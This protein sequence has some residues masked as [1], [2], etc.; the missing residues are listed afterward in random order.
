MGSGPACALLPAVNRN[1][2]LITT[3]LTSCSLSLPAC[4]S[5][6]TTGSVNDAAADVAI[7][8]GADGS[9]ASAD[10]AP[11]ASS[12]ATP[13]N[14][15]AGPDA[16]LDASPDASVDAGPDASLDAGPDADSGD[17]ALPSGFPLGAHDNC[18]YSTFL[19]TSGGGGVAGPGGAIV[20]SQ[21]GSTLTVGYGG[22][23]GALDTSL[24]F[25]PTSP[26]SATLAA[27]QELDGVR[28]ACGELAFAPAVTQLSAGALT[29]NAD[30][31]FLSVVGT[32]EPLDAGAGCTNP[33]G[34]VGF[35]VTCIDEAAPADAGIV[36]S[37]TE[38]QASRF[39][40]SYSCQSAVQQD[41]P[42]IVSVNGSES[43]LT[44][45]QAGGLLT[46]AIDNTSPV[47]GSLE[48]EATTDD[49]A[50]PAVATESVQ[51]ACVPGLTAATV[52]V[53]A[54]TLTVDGTTLVLSLEGTGC[55]GDQVSAS[56]VC[57]PSTGEGGIRDGAPE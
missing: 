28:V 43:A 41:G 47:W 40:G 55:D 50:G 17:G 10:A 34:P 44:V 26:T 5:S 37:G 39:V 4:D 38:A 57:Q 42:G 51:V 30:T 18:F 35:V 23:G 12:D 33:G 46:V 9:P 24:A 29:Y 13:P 3:L 45:T 1:R 6:N 15:D 36:D 22:D 52:A 32:A 7:G 19:Q 53:A 16:T 8:V 48:F 56:L 25:T 11:D 49:T 31:L 2:L 21:T 54:S 27:G 14:T 20:V